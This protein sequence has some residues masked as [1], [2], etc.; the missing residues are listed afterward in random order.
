MV[1]EYFCLEQGQDFKPSSA[2]L[3]YIQTWV[4]DVLPGI[5]CFLHAREI[6]HAHFARKVADVIRLL[7]MQR[8]I[9]RYVISDINSGTLPPSLSLFFYL[10]NFLTVDHVLAC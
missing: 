6:P 4:K 9:R 7:H 5:F 8:H 10:S 3:L 2:P 1:L